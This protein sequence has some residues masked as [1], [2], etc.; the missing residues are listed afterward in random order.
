[1]AI[2][3]LFYVKANLIYQ[4]P[5]TADDRV[6]M[7]FVVCEVAEDVDPEMVCAILNKGEPAE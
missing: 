5:V 4:R 1:M 6:T 2:E 3:P 7:G